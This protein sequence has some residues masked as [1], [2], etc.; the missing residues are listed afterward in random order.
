MMRR[1]YKTNPLRSLA[2]VATLAVAALTS[3]K[4]DAIVFSGDKVDKYVLPTT[5]V[6]DSL[7]REVTFPSSGETLYGFWL[8]QPGTAPRVTVVFSHGKGGNLSQDVEWSHAELLWQTGVDVLT[9]DY[10][11]FG[12]SSGKSEDETTLASDA[13]AAL[14]F[15]LAQPGVTLGRVVSY[16]H[17]LGSAPAIALVASSAGMR[18]LVVE[19]GFSN[20]QAMAES[21]NPLGIPVGWLM[22]QPMLNTTNIATVSMPV[23]I[24]H[25]DQDRLIP[26]SQGHDL[27][28]AA[29]EP[30]QLRILD[31]ASHEDVQK[32]IGASA[33]RTLIRAFIR[34]DTP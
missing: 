11:G 10:R 14:A 32:V 12:R 6:P 15:A 5:L 3:C 30:K 8:R 26:V 27:F 9:Y 28:A 19:S 31:N 4:L 1:R 22:R 21:A 33:F 2:F 29:R 25:G 24:L 18:A 7:R 23:L 20:G 17:S 13:R 16:G 34:A